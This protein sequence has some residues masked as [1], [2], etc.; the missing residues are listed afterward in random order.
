MPSSIDGSASASSRSRPPAGDGRDARGRSAVIGDVEQPPIGRRRPGPARSAGTPGGTA[1]SSSRIAEPA[2]IDR[3]AERRR[4]HRPCRPAPTAMSPG[5]R[6]GGRGEAPDD[7]E[8]GRD[9]S[10]SGRE[11]RS[12]GSSGVGSTTPEAIQSR[13]RGRIAWRR[14]TGCRRRRARHARASC[15][16]AVSSAAAD[17]RWS[18][19]GGCAAASQAMPSIRRMLGG[20]RSRTGC[21]PDDGAALAAKR[22]RLGGHRLGADQTA[23]AAPGSRPA[24]PPPSAASR[25]QRGAAPPRH[26]PPATRGAELA[27]LRSRR[28]CGKR[29]ASAIGSCDR[30]AAR[31]DRRRCRP[32]LRR[33]ARGRNGAERAAGAGEDAGR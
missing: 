4:W 12:A 17:H 2:A 8:G 19:R 5:D 10:R 13:R 26:R 21:S 6:A 15:A 20:N 16:I 31:P 9:R 23:R 29:A 11:R 1:I 28:C 18:R 24:A 30:A 25:L 3:A 14:R 27:A 22:A 7:G 32:R 33:G